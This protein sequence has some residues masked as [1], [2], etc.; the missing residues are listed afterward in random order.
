MP[1]SRRN[2]LIIILVLD[3]EFS[4]K[5]F[6]WD[7]RSPVI[8]IFECLY[9]ITMEGIGL[10]DGDGSELIAGGR[11]EIRKGGCK[12]AVIRKHKEM[13]VELVQRSSVER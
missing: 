9:L 13:E 7:R 8:V 12:G 5:N 4:G 1:G 3:A 11:L 6:G 10:L 2:E